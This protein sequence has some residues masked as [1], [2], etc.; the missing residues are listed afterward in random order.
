MQV[1]T[2]NLYA[3]CKT[4]LHKTALWLYCSGSARKQL[5]TIYLSVKMLDSF[6]YAEFLHIFM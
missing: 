3:L 6:A 4:I 1:Q 5:C 2:E